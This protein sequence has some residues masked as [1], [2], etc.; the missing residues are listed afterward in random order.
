M[1]TQVNRVTAFQ[2]A[3]NAMHRLEDDLARG[4]KVRKDDLDLIRYALRSG[5]IKALI[6]NALSDAE[7]K[8]FDAM[9]KAHVMKFFAEEDKSNVY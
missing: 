6:E 7:R 5:F 1:S 2:A 9:E 8:E 3:V 4:A